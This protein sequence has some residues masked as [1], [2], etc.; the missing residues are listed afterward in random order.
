[1]PVHTALL[2]FSNLQ[3]GILMLSLCLQP[4]EMGD[5]F[6]QYKFIDFIKYNAKG[7]ICQKQHYTTS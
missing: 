6:E 1:V 5:V 4:K 3:K 2:Q 7:I